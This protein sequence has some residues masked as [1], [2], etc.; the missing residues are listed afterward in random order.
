MTTQQ[1]KELGTELLVEAHGP[2][3]VVTLNRPESFNAADKALHGRQAHVWGELDSDSDVRAIVITAV[4]GPAV[5]LG[6]S[7][8]GMSDIVLVEEH[9]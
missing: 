7:L 9:T 8:A 5:G 2:V 4:N 3:R 1:T 6:C